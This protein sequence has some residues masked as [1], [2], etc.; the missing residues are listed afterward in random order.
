MMRRGRGVDLNLKQNNLWS[1]W[2]QLRLDRVP[3]VCEKSSWFVQRGTDYYAYRHSSFN[4]DVRMNQ[5]SDLLT[6]FRPLSAELGLSRYR[7][8]FAFAVWYMDILNKRANTFQNMPL[9]T[10]IN[11]DSRIC[12]WEKILARIQEHAFLNICY[13]GFQN[14]PLWTFIDTDSRTCLYERLLTRIQEHAFV[15]ICY[16]EFQNMPLW[17][18]IDTDSRTCLCEHLLTWIPEHAFMNIY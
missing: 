9:G 15:N 10:F 6:R 8:P 13:R 17:T 18:F 1:H 16:R 3:F 14:M 11:P 7:F 5:G 12:L 4:Y 2:I